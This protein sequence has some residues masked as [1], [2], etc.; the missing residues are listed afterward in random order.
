MADGN[1]LLNLCILLENEPVSENGG[2]LFI[3]ICFPPLSP[4]SIPPA[5][6]TYNTSR[7][8]TIESR[9]SVVGCWLASV[10]ISILSE[11]NS[12]Y[13]PG[14]TLV[15][16]TRVCLG[17][18]NYTNNQT[19]TF[20]ARATQHATCLIVMLY[21]LLQSLAAKISATRTQRDTW[22][23]RYPPA[24]QGRLQQLPG[25]TAPLKQ[26]KPTHEQ[27]MQDETWA[28]LKHIRS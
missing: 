3:K 9:L 18:A 7:H 15:P 21:S 5:P 1:Q 12:V 22:P 11:L 8:N 25:N 16:T 19:A 10:Y 14:E 20:P 6:C 24:K 26:T 28:P 13:S 27:Y 17:F 4:L 2:P 23:T